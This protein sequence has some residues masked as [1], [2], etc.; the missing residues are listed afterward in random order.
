MSNVL[1]NELFRRHRRAAHMTQEGL[2]KR[3]HIHYSNVCRIESAEQMP[4]ASYIDI[5]VEI[6]EFA[7]TAEEKEDIRLA[8]RLAREKTPRKRKTEAAPPALGAAGPSSRASALSSLF[9]VS[10]TEPSGT[11]QRYLDF[12]IDTC[13][14]S[15]LSNLGIA[16]AFA[17]VPLANVYIPAQARIKLPDAET[18]NREH[19][20][21][22]EALR[23]RQFPIRGRLPTLEEAE[24]LGD[25][26]SAPRLIV[27][28]LQEHPGLVILGDP[29]A[30]KS[31]LLKYLAATLAA[32]QG[33]KIGMPGR[34]PML[35]PIR[36]YAQAL[37]GQ[38]LTPVEF[39]EN[40]YSHQAGF[41]LPLK[42][43]FQDILKRG[44]ALVL[45]DGLDEIPDLF[46]RQ[47]VVD[48]VRKFFQWNHRAG[49]RFVL[50]SRIIGYQDAPLHAVGLATS[51][52]SEFTARD[53][54]DFVAKWT[55]AVAH[56][57]SKSPEIALRAARREEADLL[58]A[59]RRD[60]GIR[61]WAGNPLLL[62]L[63]A[64]LRHRQGIAHN[65]RAKLYDQFVQTLLHHW[66]MARS[67]DTVGMQP[68]SMRHTQ[69]LMGELALWIQQQHAQRCVVKAESARRKLTEICTAHQ[70]TN[71]E[72]EADLLLR[73]ARDY[74]GILVDLGPGEYGFIHRTLQ[75]YL[76]AY[77]I[78]AKVADDASIAFDLLAPHL[79]D[80][81]WREV[82]LLA[83]GCLGSV[84]QMEQQASDLIERLLDSTRPEQAEL[85]ALIGRAATEAG[86]DGLTATCKARV[87][88]VL[89]DLIGDDGRAAVLIRAD[90]G[91]ALAELGDLRP[92]VMTVEHMQFCCVPAGPFDMSGGERTHDESDDLVHVNSLLNYDYWLGRYP[93]TN[94][95]FETFI[96]AGGYQHAEYWAEA[97]ALGLWR[98]GEIRLGFYRWDDAFGGFQPWSTYWSDRPLSYGAPFNL[99]NHPVNNLSWYECLAFTRWL[100]DQFKLPDRGWSACLPSDP[101]W[102]KASRG[103]HER[104][105]WHL[106]NVGAVAEGGL[107]KPLSAEWLP[108]AT[109]PA[110][111]PSM[112]PAV[113]PTIPIN[114]RRFPWGPNEDPNRAN[115]RDTEIRTTNAVGIFPGGVSPYGCEE[116]IGNVWEWTRSL[117]G[118]SNF[119]RS[120]HYPYISTQDREDLSAGIEML[121]TV[122]GGS[123]F[124][125]PVHARCAYHRR[126]APDYICENLGFRVAIVPRVDM[127][128]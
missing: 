111:L 21:S 47:R 90:A 18:W 104:A 103:G 53:I 39:L 9:A 25:Y 106:S 127:R 38:E 42:A 50:T 12:L 100:N 48:R 55:E 52:L 66:N 49:N 43:L 23:G 34:I 57:S 4:D 7:L 63:M 96:Q 35:L 19:E 87:S 24:T 65:S 3:L 78:A 70:L 122:R 110:S 60:A 74:A 107:C 44:N 93:I 68:S 123:Y 72:H 61:Q 101:E 40:Y 95:Q 13:N 41:S 126:N 58:I 27:D 36:A 69:T 28:L 17:T 113:L 98:P 118:P 92:E 46:E 37:V 80:P 116:M 10:G 125:L 102:E 91:N 94:T 81:A 5:F 51:V 121:R 2:A 128:K 31:T 84:R 109:K 120:F 30:G 79:N 71:P 15:M 8:Y 54:E 88:A 86:I 115:Y 11:L 45:W 1:L 64:V 105:D 14:Q 82:I 124:S 33:E 108:P 20:H 114:L 97:A 89:L 112:A 85:R 73:H 26:L 77:A 16:T 22:A 32:G 6:E 119:E 59:L 83:V 99:P 29:G 76:A 56:N 117:W 75:E 62:T 67:L